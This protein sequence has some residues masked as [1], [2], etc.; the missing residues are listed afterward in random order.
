MCVFI[1]Y[2]IQ[3]ATITLEITYEPTSDGTG[4]AT[5]KRKGNRLDDETDENQEDDEDEQE[6]DDDDDDGSKGKGKSQKILKKKRTRRRLTR[7][8]SDKTKDFQVSI[9]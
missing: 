6:S 9:D 1:I 2:R 5:E 8:W 4:Q 3:D 7:K